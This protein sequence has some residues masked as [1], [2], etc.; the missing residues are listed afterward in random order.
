MSEKSNKKTKNFNLSMD[1][2]AIVIKKDGNVEIICAKKVGNEDITETEE[3]ALAFTFILNNNELYEMVMENYESK[4]EEIER[5]DK[6][7]IAEEFTN[8]EDD[9]QDEGEQ[10]FIPFNRKEHGNYGFDNLN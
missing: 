1:D 8:D 3:L 9:A 4:L 6:E 5:D 2:T 7:I 10:I